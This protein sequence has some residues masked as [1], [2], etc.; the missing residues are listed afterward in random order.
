MAVNRPIPESETS[1]EPLLCSDLGADL[2]LFSKGT[3]RRNDRPEAGDQVRVHGGVFEGVEGTVERRLNGSRLLIAVH[4][5]Q[6]GV[7]LEID[8][9]LITAVRSTFVPTT[10]VPSAVGP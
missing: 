5:V 2:G 4:V 7:F 8:A 6:Q 3:L 1:Y 10:F 9:G